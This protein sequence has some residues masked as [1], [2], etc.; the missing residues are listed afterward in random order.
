MAT[1]ERNGR[2]LAIGD[3]HGNR[4][5]LEECLEACNYNPNSDTLLSVGDLVDG[6]PESREIIDFF[7]N[8]E[9]RVLIRGNHDKWFRDFLAEVIDKAFDYQDKKIAKN[10]NPTWWKNGGEATYDSYDWDD[11]RTIIK[12]FEFLETQHL[13]VVDR[14]REYLYLHG[15]WDTE[16]GLEGT[17]KISPSTIYWDRKLLESACLKEY[18]FRCHNKVPTSIDPRFKHIFIGHTCVQEWEHIILDNTVNKPLFASNIIDIDTGAGWEGVLTIM[19]VDSLEFWQSATGPT[20][21][22]EFKGRGKYK[23]K[24]KFPDEERRNTQDII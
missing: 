16:L 11:W 15:G 1:A 18:Y 6:Y 14:T 2:V 10:F 21:Y 7:M 9:K 22:P 8:I 23:S 13:Y 20:L 5:A 4:R 17:A 24:Y 3:I 19:D 12:H